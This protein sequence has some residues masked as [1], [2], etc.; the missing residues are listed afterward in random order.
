MVQYKHCGIHYFI[1]RKNYGNLLHNYF[2]FRSNILH[3][4]FIHEVWMDMVENSGHCS[5]LKSNAQP[6]QRITRH[7]MWFAL[8][9]EFLHN[10]TSEESLIWQV[11]IVFQSSS[12]QQG[13]FRWYQ[14]FSDV[15]IHFVGSQGFQSGPHSNVSIQHSRH[16]HK[17]TQ[18]LWTFLPKVDLICFEKIRKFSLVF[19]LSDLWYQG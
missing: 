4:H 11:Y 16:D 14:I 12:W 5:N 2:I 1:F 6:M 10:I 15:L 19:S 17:H 18:K 9:F 8:I 13:Q 3:N 7:I